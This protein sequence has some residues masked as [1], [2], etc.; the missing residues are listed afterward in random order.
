MV[1]SISVFAQTRMYRDLDGV[2]GRD[3]E[4]Q[5]QKKGYSHVKTDKTSNSIYSY[6]WNYGS[7]TCICEQISDGRVKSIV[8]SLPADCNKNSDGSVSRHSNYESSSHHYNFNSE[9]SNSRE[10]RDAF[11]RGFKDGKYNKAYHNVYDGSRMIRSYQDGYVKG[12][13]YRTN[14]TGHHSREAG[15]N[16]KGF[17]EWK[18]L[19]GH[20]AEN[21]YRQLENRGFKEVKIAHTGGTT[22]R[23]FHH[24]KTGQCI[25]TVSVQKEIYK[26]EH[27]DNCNKYL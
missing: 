13:Q 24:S 21:A 23:L 26:I 8:K 5:L 20:D 7:K 25:V 3:A 19:I 4:V 11:E 16:S 22:R 12:V 18:D 17:V 6:W 27:S 2:K 1:F 14:N 15:Y 9:Y 10:M